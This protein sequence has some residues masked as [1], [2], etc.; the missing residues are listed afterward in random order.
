[1][2]E[3]VAKSKGTW[4]SGLLGRV[5]SSCFMIGYLQKKNETLYK[6]S[7]LSISSLL[8]KP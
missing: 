8:S 3:S 2:H 6:T 5:Y 1:M 4:S 7:L